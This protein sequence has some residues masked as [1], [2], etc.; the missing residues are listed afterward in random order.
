MSAVSVAPGALEQVRTFLNTWRLPNDT[1]TPEDLLPGLAG[2]E[3]SWRAALPDVAPVG[4][5]EWD[6]L[7]RLRADLRDALGERTPDGLREWLARH[8]VVA[9]LGDD[10]PVRHRP[11]HPGAVGDLLALVVDA[12]AYGHWPRLKACPDCRHV[13][14]DHSRNRSRTWCGMYAERPDGRACGSIAKVRTYRK[15]RREQAV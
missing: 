6:E 5:G 10:P 7:L 15:R 12:V 13:F 1:R 14:Y 4:E 3:A 8:P 9:A 2:A 11:Q